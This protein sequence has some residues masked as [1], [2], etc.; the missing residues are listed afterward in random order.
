MT[1]KNND[2]GK[3][4]GDT[5][6][7][8]G[9]IQFKIKLDEAKR[10]Q[11]SPLETA[12]KLLSGEGFQSFGKTVKLISVFQKLYGY[13]PGKED[14]VSWKATEG[15]AAIIQGYVDHPSA[16]EFVKIQEEAV[17]IKG[18]LMH[19]LQLENIP[20]ETFLTYVPNL[21][22][23]WFL[24]NINEQTIVQT[25]AIAGNKEEYD[26]L[27]K[28]AEEDIRVSHAKVMASEALHKTLMKD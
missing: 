25:L 12:Q 23:S 9:D 13:I 28:K 22:K 1:D 11:L 18:A 8:I 2:F 3:A 20:L 7:L 16:D 19:L 6:R 26:F 14:V 4:K 10:E 15:Y 27:T 24:A 17:T 21:D 5:I